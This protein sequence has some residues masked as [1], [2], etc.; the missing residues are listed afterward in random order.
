MVIF[1]GAYGTGREV[2]EFITRQGALGGLMALGQVA[3]LFILVLYLSFEY[4][5]R[6][7]LWEYQ[8]FFRSLIG[9]GWVIFEVLF[10]AMLLLVLAVNISAASVVLET[11][12]SWERNIITG[13]F[14]GVTV[15]M[16]SLG[17][18]MVKR[19]MIA[20]MIMLAVAFL[21]GIGLIMGMD[22]P[23]SHSAQGMPSAGPGWAISGLQFAL[24][25]IA[26]IPVLLYSATAISSSKQALGAAIVAGLAGVAPALV[27][28]I[29]F[30][31]HIP[32]IVSAEYPV[33]TIL[34][35]LGLGGM[36]PGYSLLLF[37]MLVLTAVGLL[38]GLNERVGNGLKNH[39]LNGQSLGV[40][41][42]VPV[43][44][45][46]LSLLVAKFGL[47]ALIARGY[48]YIG[49]GFLII[50]IL[51]LLLLGTWRMFGKPVNAD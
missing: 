18:V 31:A 24:Y 16:L 27:M 49:W 8:S 29:A 37:A 39:G 10:L 25:N 9:R 5:R 47:I 32:A 22:V 20:G 23:V 46:L 13:L 44:V 26:A 34:S 42:L 35:D 43:V 14:A 48:G 28:H 36:L 51:P 11:V 50:Y 40:R 1:G 21:I 33:G 45:L 7:H 6:E 12:V 30:S 15:V 17:S 4:A 19:L 38:Q 2:V 3:A 41:V